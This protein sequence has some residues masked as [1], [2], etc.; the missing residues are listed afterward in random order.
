MNF[1]SDNAVGA[2]PRV[3]QAL[4]ACNEG[5][6]PAYGADPVS[7]R[8][9]AAIRE[10]LDLP[11]AVVRF[12]ATGTAANALICAQFSPPYGRIYCH[13]DAH[14]QTGECA[15]PGF[16]SHGAK[17]VGIP[18]EAGR[19]PPEALALAIRAGAEPGLTHGVNALVSVTNA[20]EWGTVYHP[21]QLAD[22]AGLAHGAGLALHVDGARFANAV[23]RLGCAPADLVAG[24]DALAFGGTKNGA[25]AAEAVVIADPA[26]A[27]G[28]D[29]RRKQAGHVFSKQRYLAAQMLALVEDGL[30]LDL[31]RHANA[32]AQGLARGITGAGAEVLV[33]VE[34]NQ[35]FARIPA[36]MHAHLRGHGA[37]FH[38]WQDVPPAPGEAVTIRLVTSWATHEDEVAGFLALLQG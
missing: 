34:T 33:P 31:A 26:H 35:V 28:F 1:T 19:I 25:L 22:L 29:H 11:E 17:L 15:A 36:E 6:M 9:E 5:A 8:A 7:L 37:G 38:L 14:I 3:L 16:F 18:G 4:L 13:A 30:W 32:M 12:V 21:A 24:V 10:L 23:A 20:T 2:H 27:Q